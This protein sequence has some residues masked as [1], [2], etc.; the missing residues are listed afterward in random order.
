MKYFFIILLSVA[1][2]YSCSENTVKDSTSNVGLAS[3]ELSIEGMSC[4]QMCGGAIC[5]GLE[6]IDGVA[7]TDL[8]FSSDNPV[9]MVTVKFDPEKVSHED[10]TA[11]VESLAGGAY[12][13][14]SV[15]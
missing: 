10:M 2:L 8:K 13:V 1:T 9:D 4:E 7:S 14:K 15:K 11:K 5:K 3:V 12:K 6:K